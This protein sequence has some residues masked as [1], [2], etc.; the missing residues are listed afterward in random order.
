MSARS[1][2]ILVVVLAALAGTGFWLLRNRWMVVNALPVGLRDAI[3]GIRY[4]YRVERDV[5]IPMPDGVKLATN[6]YFP[7]GTGPADTGGK[8]PAVLIRLPYDKNH[9]AG[10]LAPAQEFA[11]HGYVVAIQDMRGKYASEGV[12]TPSRLDAEDGSATVDWL[13]AQPWSN[14]RVGTVGCSSLGESQIMLARMRNPHHA[15]MI[16]LGAGGAI[17]SAANRYTYFGQYEGGVFQLASGFG[18][19]L[20]EGGKSP[21]AEFEGKI[22]VARAI[23]ELPSGSLVRR[24]RPDRTDFDDFISKPLGDPYWRDLGYIA[25][26][27]RFATPALVF[28]TWQDQ[29]VAETLVL[30]EVMKRN[31]ASEAARTHYHVIIGPGNHCQYFGP[32]QTM[33][34]G[35]FR[36]GPNAVA[37]YSAWQLQWFDHWLKRDGLKGKPPEFPAYRF[38][39]MGADRWMDSAQWPPAGVQTQRWYLGGEGAANSRNGKGVLHP[40]APTTDHSDEFR[41]DPLKPVPTRGGPICCTNDPAQVQGMVDQADVETRDDVLV[42]TSPVLESDLTIAGPLRADL[43]VS[44]SAKDTDLV[45]RL[46]DV[47]PDGRALNIQE[48]ALRLR[49][50]D[51]FVSPQLMTPGEVYRVSVDMR[52]IAY[53]LPKGHRLRLQIASSNFPRLERNLNTGGNNY[54]ESQPVVATN[55]ILRSPGYPS[56]VLL[57]V[58]PEG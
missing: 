49:Y 31:A 37:P 15:A 42:Y 40:V 53:R 7:R 45:A 41:Y 20:F 4:G 13:A 39:V 33:N 51:S 5:M 44:S 11:G 47:F 19:F 27:D 10:G 43:Y 29:T 46:V 56:A 22:D 23:W 1:W 2:I 54:D 50:R 35:E 58:L 21:G 16:P 57:P 18:W 24:H 55:R 8:L 32:N 9:H 48:G 34:V 52:A 38:Y 30:A 17:G 36:V 26:E 14:G 28:N 25:D 3:F 12:F 6:L